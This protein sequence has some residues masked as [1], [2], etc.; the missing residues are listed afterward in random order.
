MFK[1]KCFWGGADAIEQEVNAF[2]A[3]LESR[4]IAAHIMFVTEYNGMLVYT[5]MTSEEV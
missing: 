3:D 2:F 1:A 5:Y 4:Q